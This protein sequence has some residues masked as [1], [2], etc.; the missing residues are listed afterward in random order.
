MRHLYYSFC[1]T[2]VL[3]SMATAAN[4]DEQ[5]DAQAEQ[6]RLEINKQQR[7]L[8]D[9][10]IEEL[11]QETHRLEQQNLDRQL[12]RKRYDQARERRKWIGEEWDRDH[13]RD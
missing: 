6:H 7:S 5:S 4:S 9:K 12:E 2:L 13:P 1:F 8:E 3:F 11:Q 10:K